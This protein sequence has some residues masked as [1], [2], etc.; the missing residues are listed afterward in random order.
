MLVMEIVGNAD[1]DH[2]SDW[3]QAVFHALNDFAAKVAELGANFPIIAVLDRFAWRCTAPPVY[4]VSRDGRS[5]WVGNGRH[6]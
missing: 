6:Q 3:P 5:R 1:P 4:P 2:L